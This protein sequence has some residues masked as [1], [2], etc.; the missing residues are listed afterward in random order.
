MI[1][2]TNII[3]GKNSAFS[4]HFKCIG[5]KIKNI[6]RT[7]NSAI[8]PLNRSTL[9]TSLGNLMQVN[10][11]DLLEDIFQSENTYISQDQNN[12]PDNQQNINTVNNINSNLNKYQND[13]NNSQYLYSNNNKNEFYDYTNDYP[14][15]YTNQYPAFPNPPL[16]STFQPYEYLSSPPNDFFSGSYLDINGQYTHMEEY[17]INIYDYSGNAPFNPLNDQQWGPENNDQFFYT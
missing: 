5:Y 13:T 3:N 6:P 4:N 15:Q 9:D 14:N 12:N 8:Y 7:E 2:Y 17:P 10:Q 11:L 16:A 1:L